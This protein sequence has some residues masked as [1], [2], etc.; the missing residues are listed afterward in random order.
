MLKILQ[1]FR[2]SFLRLCTSIYQD[3]GEEPVPTVDK[4]ILLSLI[5][6]SLDEAV[7]PDFC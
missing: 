6:Y 4:F 3:E 7:M 2:P 5:W 1:G